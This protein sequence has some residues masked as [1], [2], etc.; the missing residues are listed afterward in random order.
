M[1]NISAMGGRPE[2]GLGLKKKGGSAIIKFFTMN[3]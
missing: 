3:N 2:G 1:S